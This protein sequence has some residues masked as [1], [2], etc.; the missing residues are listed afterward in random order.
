MVSIAAL[1]ATAQCC[2][3]R[4]KN[5]EHDEP[6]GIINAGETASADTW[7]CDIA[8]RNKG[9]SKCSNCNRFSQPVINR[10]QLYCIQS[11][12]RSSVPLPQAS[13]SVRRALPNPPVSFPSHAPIDSTSAFYAAFEKMN[14]VQQRIHSIPYIEDSV[15]PTYESI[16]AE[17]DSCSDPL[18]SKLETRNQSNRKYDYPTF[19]SQNREGVSDEAVYQSASQIYAGGSE[20]PYSSI[21]SNSGIYGKYNGGYAIFNEVSEKNS[22]LRQ[23]ANS[24]SAKNCD[25]DQLYTKIQRD[26]PR[27]RRSHENVSLSSPL[28]SRNGFE[29]VAYTS[30]ESEKTS[31]EPSYRYITVRESVD[32]IRQ[33]IRE[34]EE[35][36]RR[37][38]NNQNEHSMDLNISNR[39]HFYASIEG[40]SDYESVSGNAIY[41]H[42]S[43]DAGQK[44]D[45]VVTTT[46][47]ENS[48]NTN[49]NSVVPKPPTS[50]IPAHQGNNENEV[51]I[52]STSCSTSISNPAQYSNRCGSALIV[53]PY[54]YFSVRSSATAKIPSSSSNTSRKPNDYDD[55]IDI[56][57]ECKTFPS[58]CSL[59]TEN[60]VVCDGSSV[61]EDSNSIN[62]NDLF[63]SNGDAD[64][65]IKSLENNKLKDEQNNWKESSKNIEKTSATKLNFATNSRDD[66]LLDSPTFHHDE[67]TLNT[68]GFLNVRVGGRMEFCGEVLSSD[69][70]DQLSRNTL[71][72][73]EESDLSEV[74]SYKQRRMTSDSAVPNSSKMKIPVFGHQDPYICSDLHFSTART[75]PPCSCSLPKKLESTS[76]SNKNDVVSEIVSHSVDGLQYL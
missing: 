71:K 2:K 68:G 10:P 23:S 46:S 57:L 50:P 24:G 28:G 37:G 61:V 74:E 69:S 51:N 60:E 8:F 67:S 4:S 49:F 30:S 66:N 47:I 72:R 22:P 9:L 29:F 34:R 63:N 44:C 31:R 33:R 41:E 48:G 18:Y 21:T 58:N 36:T 38:D 70:L 76:F 52:S 53:G 64:A 1:C 11:S 75:L 12:Q 5:F 43:E 54:S 59:N 39:E 45:V 16:D 62:C 20:D 13:S 40:S 32:V 17:T 55:K 7:A 19:T 27:K 65:V 56:Q 26:F 15:N 42:L 14:S 35:I 25:V 6:Y 3:R 73:S